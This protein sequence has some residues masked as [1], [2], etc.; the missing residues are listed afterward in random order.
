MGLYGPPEGGLQGKGAG[1]NELVVALAQLGW[2]L[3]LVGIV[4]DPIGQ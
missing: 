4:K 2:N 3:D 1:Q